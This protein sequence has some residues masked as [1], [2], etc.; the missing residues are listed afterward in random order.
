MMALENRYLLRGVSGIKPGEARCFEDTPLGRVTVVNVAGKYHATDDTCPHAVAS[1]SE[2]LVE[3][4][5]LICALH[6]AEFDVRTGEVRNAPPDCGNLTIHQII[7]E[8]DQY[9]LIVPQ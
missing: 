8:G 2:G 7:E 1:L 4:H 9:Y 5:W 6:F 3:D